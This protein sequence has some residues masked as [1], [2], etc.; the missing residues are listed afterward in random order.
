MDVKVQ[1]RKIRMR[2]S[3]RK[4][5]KNLKKDVSNGQA[6]DERKS[7]LKRQTAIHHGLAYDTLRKMV[8]QG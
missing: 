7:E 3:V 2:P 8:D 4:N 1:Q 6:S 5:M